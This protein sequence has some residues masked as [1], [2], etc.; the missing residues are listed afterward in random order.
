M[1]SFV[2]LVSSVLDGTPT[3]FS[4]AV[5]P[6]ALVAA[7]VAQL[8]HRLGHGTP[9]YARI[10]MIRHGRAGHFVNRVLLRETVT[11]VLSVASVLALLAA[12]FLL[13]GGRRFDDPH[14]DTAAWALHLAVNAPAQLLVYAVGVLIV[15]WITPAVAARGVALVVLIGA[16]LIPWPVPV[17]IGLTRL[18]LVHEGLPAVAAAALVLVVTLAVLRAALA[19]LADRREMPS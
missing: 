3:P 18:N 10:S 9:G 16:S 14:I 8:Q 11:V 1:T 13:S 19:L 2:R 7:Y 4:G 15:A 17:P 5:I 12:V 6:V